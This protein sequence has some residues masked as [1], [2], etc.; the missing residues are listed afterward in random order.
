MKLKQKIGLFNVRKFVLAIADMF[1]IGVSA[2][3]A[4]YV[5]TLMN[6]LP[7]QTY[8]LTWQ[9]AIAIL[10]GF[11]ALWACGAYSKLW[12]YFKAKDYLSCLLGVT[13][14]MV[15]VLL[16]GR[17]G[18]LSEDT[19]LPS[20]YLFVL[21][22]YLFSVTGVISF[23]LIFRTTFL[24][25][26]EVG[27]NMHR[28]RTLLVGAGRAG[29]I[30]I[31]EIMN[32][33]ETDEVAKQYHIVGIVD[34]NKELTGQKIQDIPIIGTTDKIESICN[35]EYIDTILMAIPSCSEEERRRILGECS[36]TTCKIKVIPYVGNLIFDEYDGSQKSDKKAVT[37]ISQLNDI[38]M[39]DLL[40]RPPISFDNED[41]RRLIKDRVCMVTGGG[42]SIG[43]EL[44]RQI[45]RFSPKQ[46]IIV[47]IYENN[48]YE[49]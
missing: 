40:G 14:S 25:L 13:F 27:E 30:I 23:R 45:A 3:M 12:R 49:I 34:D 37:V 44:V 11:L 39:E 26:V 10:V 6:V 22:E 32:A 18:T 8:I 31:K 9:T 42:G 47:D 21:F 16:A 5:L 46:I 48:A 28:K 41:T 24:T 19:D 7:I 1:I 29:K 20:F 33:S 38:N 35:K 36:K 15:V 17:S 43:S 2:L 4:N